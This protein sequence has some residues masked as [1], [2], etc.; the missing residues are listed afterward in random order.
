M[1]NKPTQTAKSD[2]QLIDEAEAAFAAYLNEGNRSL[3]ELVK[4]RLKEP[5]PTWSLFVSGI[6]SIAIYRVIT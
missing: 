5:V 6:I 3:W 4:D 2:D 1:T